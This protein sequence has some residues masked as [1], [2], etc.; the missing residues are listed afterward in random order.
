M[1]DPVGASKRVASTLAEGGTFMLF[2]PFA[3][4]NLE[5]NSHPLEQIYYSFAT[6]VCAPNSL[7]QEVGLAPGVQAGQKRLTD[8]LN[9]GGLGLVRLDTKTPTNIVLEARV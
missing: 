6:T 5:D 4:D 1:G 7:S 2:E 9:E 3:K 8:V